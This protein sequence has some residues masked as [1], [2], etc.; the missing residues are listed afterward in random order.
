MKIIGIIGNA[1]AFEARI[2]RLGYSIEHYSWKDLEEGKIKDVEAVLFFP[3][4]E[5][6]NAWR[7]PS[8][9]EAESILK[10]AQSGVGVYTERLKTYGWRMR[11]AIGTQR[12]LDPRITWRERAFIVNAPEPFSSFGKGDIL[13]CTERPTL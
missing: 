9:K 11:D 6:L 8:L 2:K 7:E 5:E 3:D 12:F 1:G 10:L 4:S 13:D